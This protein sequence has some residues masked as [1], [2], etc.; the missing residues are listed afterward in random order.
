MQRGRTES[1][2]WALEGT[3]EWPLHPHTGPIHLNMFISFKLH[4]DADDAVLLV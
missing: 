4:V 3:A 2:Q 1:E